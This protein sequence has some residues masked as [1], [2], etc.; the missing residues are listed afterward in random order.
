MD[1]WTDLWIDFWTV[2]GRVLE[3]ILALKIHEKSI[4]ILT[5]ILIDFLMAF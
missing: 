4:K 3:A 5:N 2:F 1:F